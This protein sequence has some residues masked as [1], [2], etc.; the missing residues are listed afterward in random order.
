MDKMNELVE[1]YEAY[2]KL[3]EEE[4]NEVVGLAFVHGWRSTRYEAGVECRNRIAKAKE[5]K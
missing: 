5:Q 4:L 1:A 3:L 2:I